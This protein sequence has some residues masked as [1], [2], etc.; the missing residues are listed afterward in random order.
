M[1]ASASLIFSCKKGKLRGLRLQ[2]SVLHFQKAS[3]SGMKGG[4]RKRF[5]PARRVDIFLQTDERGLRR[6]YL[7]GK[8][9][10]FSAGCIQKLLSAFL[11]ALARALQVGPLRPV[12]GA[13]AAA[14]PAS[15]GAPRSAR[16]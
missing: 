4:L 14:R 3:H 11:Q 13:R 15:T 5:R 16:R 6:I 9:N 7:L 10:D 8:R 12:P 2:V 1:R